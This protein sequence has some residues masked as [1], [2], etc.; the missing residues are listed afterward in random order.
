MKD[1]SPHV[2]QMLELLKD[3]ATREGLLDDISCL[4]IVRQVQ[5]KD[6]PDQPLKM[7]VVGEDC[8]T[9]IQTLHYAAKVVTD[10]LRET[11]AKVVA[12]GGDVEA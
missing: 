1:I 6:E 12:G 3:Y 7:A 8:G 9:A 5:S 10:A 4:L 11:T 2:P